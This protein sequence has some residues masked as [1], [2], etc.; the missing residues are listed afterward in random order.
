MTWT[1]TWDGLFCFCRRKRCQMSRLNWAWLLD[2]VR[3]FGVPPATDKKGQNGFVFRPTKWSCS[4]TSCSIP[5]VLLALKG[6]PTRL[7]LGTRC[8]I[9]PLDPG[10][11][12]LTTPPSMD[13][14]LLPGSWVTYKLMT[15]LAVQRGT[16]H[17]T[18]PSGSNSVGR[19]PQLQGP[20]GWTKMG[21]ETVSRIQQIETWHT[22]DDA[23]SSSSMVRAGV[24]FSGG[25]VL[26]L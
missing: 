11:T 20:L 3:P 12:G 2:L 23:L 6:L 9:T 25:P 18:I 13:K 7:S 24:S 8:A 17:V 4:L 14:K 22:V 15:H 19:R 10:R 16:E 5:N 21:N 1:H 26:H